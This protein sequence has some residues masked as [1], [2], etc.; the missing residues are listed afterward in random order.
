MQRASAAWG[1]FF[2][3]DR[4]RSSSD[5]PRGGNVPE[6][7]RLILL[8]FGPELELAIRG[9]FEEVVGSP[10][11]PRFTIRLDGAPRKTPR[12]VHSASPIV[13]QSESAL[14]NAVDPRN[15]EAQR[16]RRK[17]GP[18]RGKPRPRAEGQES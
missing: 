11:P 15:R 5:P 8:H 17:G 9:A 16:P 13:T 10:L 12:T 18:S 3:L 7:T 1:V 2:G 14:P 6:L 4:P